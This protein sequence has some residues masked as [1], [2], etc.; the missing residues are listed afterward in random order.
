M[1]NKIVVLACSVVPSALFSGMGRRMIIITSNT[2]RACLVM[3]KSRSRPPRPYE[4]AIA[5]VIVKIVGV[6]KNE[7]CNAGY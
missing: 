6:T 2:R 7:R 5:A 4:Q 1:K 3:M